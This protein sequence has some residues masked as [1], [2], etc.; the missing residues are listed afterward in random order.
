[1][2]HEATPQNEARPPLECRAKAPQLH[3]A[4]VLALHEFCIYYGWLFLHTTQQKVRKRR[5]SVMAEV[6]LRLVVAAS[7][8][9]IAIINPQIP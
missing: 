7:G 5:Q 8:V 1:M 9:V 4:T 2:P 6:Q 3:P